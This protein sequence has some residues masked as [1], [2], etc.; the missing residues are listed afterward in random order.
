MRFSICCVLLIWAFL[1]SFQSCEDP[2][3]QAEPPALEK[4]PLL[5]KAIDTTKIDTTKVT[6]P[7]TDPWTRI[8][9]LFPFR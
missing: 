4:I 6:T 2:T 8:N 9:R 7:E 5:E 1:S 3:Y